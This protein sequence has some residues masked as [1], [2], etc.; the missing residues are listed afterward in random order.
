MKG[1]SVN[2]TVTDRVCLV[3]PALSA[4]EASSEQLQEW[5][6]DTFRVRN[7][8]AAVRAEYLA[9]LRRREGSGIAETVLREDGLLPPRRARQELETATELEKLPKTREGL[10]RGEISPD[11][12]RILAAAS[13]RGDIDEGELVDRARSQS[14][15]KFA[16]TV[17]RHERARAEDDGVK[18]LEHQ[19]RQRFAKIKTSLDDGMTVLYGRFDPVTGA[20]IKAVLSHKMNQLWHE[21][22]PNNRVTAGQRMADALQIL[23]TSPDQKDKSKQKSGLVGVRLLLMAD[24]DTISRQ[25]GNGRLADG[26][27]VPARTL[28]RLACDAQVL[29]AIFS[30]GSQPLD[31][32]R[33]R[34]AANTA[35]RAALVARDRHCVGCGA[36]S[37]WCQAHHITHWQH[38]GPTNLD[39]LT[40][41]CSRC[42]HRVHDEDWQV[43]QKPTGEFYLRRPPRNHH[44]HR[45]E[46]PRTNRQQR[47]TIK[48]GR[49]PIIKQRK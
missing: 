45:A 1:G 17:R 10:R 7:Q 13:Q 6:Q 48:Q 31:L 37:D 28:R 47:S 14:P 46:Q 38:G 41:L 11:N 16:G 33:A 12:A 36:A 34:R 43:L 18:R 24:Y 4:R 39:N 5:I 15:D 29:P 8:A 2:G 49:R 44:R 26:T 21:E 20:Q 30:G 19:R 40:L 3:V 22:D 23:L 32:G 35:Q 25:M 27:P 9:E 42:H